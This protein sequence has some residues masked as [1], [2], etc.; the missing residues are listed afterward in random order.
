MHL[1]VAVI[2]VWIPPPLL[3]VYEYYFIYFNY[4]YLLKRVYTT[5]SI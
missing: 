5:R 4:I 2:F 3:Y 1:Y